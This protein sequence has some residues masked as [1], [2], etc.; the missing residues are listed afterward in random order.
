VYLDAFFEIVNIQKAMFHEVSQI[1]SELPKTESP[2]EASRGISALETRKNWI[3]F[4]RNIIDSI[5]NHLETICQT[6]KESKYGRH[7]ILA[8]LELVEFDYQDGR[9]TL[10]NPPTYVNDTIQKEI[11]MKCNKIRKDCKKIL[12]DLLPTVD[13]EYFQGQCTDR[14][15]RLLSNVDELQLAAENSRQ[16]TKEEKLEIFRAMSSEFIGSGKINLVVM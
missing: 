15:I 3:I 14:I 2:Y 16:L 8:S 6:C 13:L 11:K 9:F 4:C 12:T 7:L 1:I 5:K 10:N